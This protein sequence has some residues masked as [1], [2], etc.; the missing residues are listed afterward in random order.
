MLVRPNAPLIAHLISFGAS[1][2]LG[3]LNAHQI[4]NGFLQ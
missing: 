2:H 1:D 3:Y 4:V